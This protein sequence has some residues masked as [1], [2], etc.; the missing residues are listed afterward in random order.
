M[1]LGPFIKCPHPEM[2]EACGVAGFDFV[3]VD[4][5]HTPVEKRALYFLKLAS[6]ARGI[7]MIVRVPVLAEEYVKWCL[8]LG[9][10]TIQVPFVQKAEDAREAVRLS[11]FSPA[12]ERGLCRFVRAADF[13]GLPVKDYLQKAN[14]SVRLILQIEGA[15]GM[16]NIDEILA[17]EGIDTLFIGPYDLSQ[18]LGVPGSIWDEKVVAAMR[19]IIGKC[20]R[21]G[22]KVGT[23]TDTA[24]GVKFW[25]DAGVEMIQY[26]SDL[27]LFMAGTALLKRQLSDLGVVPR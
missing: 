21:R 8:D 11:H 10:T 20:A 22:I 25:R 27:Y 1:R 9:I 26:G 7:E 5:E 23:F 16:R 24:E 6:L 2:I 18:S 15:E 17:I 12:G 4:M 19:D 14:S 3:V 13:S